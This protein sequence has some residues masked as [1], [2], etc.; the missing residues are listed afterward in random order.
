MRFPLRQFGVELALAGG[1]V[2]PFALE[3]ANPGTPLGDLHL[4][5]LQLARQPV[6]ILGRSV[7]ALLE[8]RDA[9]ADLLELLL[10]D[11]RQLA[12]RVLRRGRGGQPQQERGNHHSRVRHGARV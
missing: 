3:L 1:R 2:I 9:F 10:L 11:L 5:L 4:E 6:A 7:H 12:V 8:V